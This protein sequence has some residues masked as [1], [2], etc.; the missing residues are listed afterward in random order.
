MDDHRDIHMPGAYPNLQQT[1][2]DWQ[3]VTVPQKNSHQAM[4]K[5][6]SYWPRGKVLG[7]SSSINAMIHIRGSPKDYDRWEKVY[8]AKGWSWNDVFPYFKKS[9]DWGGSDGDE[10]YHG[11][12][13]P[14]R[15]ENAKYKTPS[16]HWFMSAA[17][18]AGFKVTDPN[19]NT[20]MGVGYTQVTHK[21]GA[22][23]STAQAYLHPVRWR[24]NL[25]L[26]LRTHVI[27]NI[28]LH[29]PALDARNSFPK[30]SDDFWRWY[31]RQIAGTAYHASGTC[32]MGGKEDRKAV[33]DPWLRTILKVGYANE[34]DYIIVG[35]GSAGCVLANRLSRNPNLTV[36]LIEAGG[37][38]DHRDIHMPDWQYV[39]VPQ[40]NSHQAMKKQQSYWPRGKVLGGSSSINAMIHIRGSP[41]DYDRGRRLELHD[42]KVTGVIVRDEVTG[43]QRII[44]ARREVILSAG[45]VGSTHILL[46]S[47]IGPA[48]HLKEAQIP[49]IQDLPVGKNL[50]DHLMLPVSYLAHNIF[51][52][53]LP[54]LPIIQWGTCR[55]GGKED[56]EAVVDPQLR[57]RGI[58]NLRVVDASVMPEIISGNTNTPVIIIAEKASDLIKKNN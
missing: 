45:T 31:T 47:G 28:S 37:M 10:G 11:N 32:R 20:Q 36:L 52:I 44:R 23:W 49:V 39:T 35:A 4:K 42:K 27:S 24:D 17:K 22:R 6:Q 29:C 34:Y 53:Q 38:D 56:K 30:D 48:E 14:L 26:L 55:M 5:Q 3:Y 16:A 8:G 54:A 7:G 19:G 25:F 13:G 58:E 50:Q 41:K 40:K 1:S 2:L 18:E 46:L 51:S 57:V 9:E 21:N 33:V 12:G 15:V 43:K